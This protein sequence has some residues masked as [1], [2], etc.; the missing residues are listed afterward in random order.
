MDLVQLAFGFVNAPLFATFLLGMF[1][2]RTTGHGAFFG[3]LSGMLAATL[4][5]GLTVS[6]G[7]TIFLKGGW[8]AHWHVYGSEMALNFWTAIVAWTT[9]FLVT[10]AVS[11]LTTPVKADADLCGLVYSLTP[12]V[13]DEAAT[14]WFARPV[15][16]AVIVLAATLALNVIFW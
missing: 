2:Q 12:R 6:A 16:L 13:K 15:T 4:H 7:A 9:C 1:W 14:R 10:I 11:L 5:H 8:L 3:L